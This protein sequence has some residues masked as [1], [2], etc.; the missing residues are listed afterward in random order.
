M[1]G[2]IKINCPLAGPRGNGIIGTS[3]GKSQVL[4]QPGDSVCRK[5]PAV[6]LL[7]ARQQGVDR[8]GAI[9]Q[10]GTGTEPAGY[11]A[12]TEIPTNPIE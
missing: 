12:E 11:L 7:Y 9:A 8:L 1:A 2:R 3:S 5:N 10:K 4:L 6:I